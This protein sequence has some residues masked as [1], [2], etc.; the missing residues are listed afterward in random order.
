MT[1]AWRGPVFIVGC[2][3]SGTTLLQQM[4]NAHSRLA[5]APE[6]HFIRLYW[7]PSGRYGDLSS[8][9]V[10]ERLLGDI[11][12]SDEFAELGIERATFLS[13]A[14]Q[15]EQR[16]FPAVFGLLMELFARAKGAD[17]MGEKTPAHVQ[18][19]VR[20]L[21]AFPG[22]R[23]IHVVRDPRAV[24]NSRLRQSWS[25]NTAG[26]NALFWVEAVVAARRQAP[27]LGDGLATI[28]YEELVVRP[29]AVLRRLCAFLSVEWEPAM[30]E[31][32]KH[33]TQLVSV[34][35]EPWKAGALQPLQPELA[36][37][38]RQELAAEDVAAVE[39]VAWPLMRRF[40][41]RAITPPHRLLPSVALRVTRDG[42][43]GLRRL[44][45][46]LMEHG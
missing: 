42:M 13:A 32:W 39:T 35:R 2:S 41:Y 12:A 18:H 5:I 37:R 44:A 22:A 25:H 7:G 10:F 11:A 45:R 46:R 16:S 15:T 26:D 31:Y 28:P 29:E 17:V 6:T 36:E 9:I 30:L 4:L 19:M 27:R 8:D 21:D 38:W 20:L 24:V 34:E 14:R 1:G 40:G 23:F 33:H 3:R 43:T